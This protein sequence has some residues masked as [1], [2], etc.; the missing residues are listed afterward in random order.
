MN[1]S[2]SKEN[3]TEYNNYDRTNQH[4]WI[5]PVTIS[6]VLFCATLFLLISI[7]HYG[8]KTK[9][10]RQIQRYDSD[11]LNAGLVYSTLLLC[12][13]VCLLQYAAS[14]AF[15]N[16]GF[17]SGE[18]EL[19]DAVSHVE[20]CFYFLT[21]FSVELFLWLR[22]RAFYSNRMLNVHFSRTIR[23]VSFLSIFVISTFSLLA[24]VFETLSNHH[25]TNKG[26][27]FKP[28]N[29]FLTPYVIFSI[30]MVVFGQS[31][32]IG[33]LF[34]ALQQTNKPDVRETMLCKYFASCCSSNTNR[35]AANSASPTNPVDS[36]IP[37]RLTSPASSNRSRTKSS[38]VV[39]QILMQTLI[40][41]IISVITDIIVAITTYYI[42]DPEEHRELIIIMED[43]NAF[44]NLFIILLSF[45]QWKSIVISPY[46]RKENENTRV[47]V[48]SF[49]F[50]E[51]V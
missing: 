7:V 2:N 43:I 23:W 36:G 39:K 28:N 50:S 16:I 40:F 44:F 13:V 51:A 8:M 38:I 25:V 48:K 9:K 31:V 33:L 10:W 49:S 3:V 20:H 24:L 35:K 11:K 32:L 15:L 21:L 1:Y 45:L 18:D 29:R 37:S 26:C 30:C 27:K 6:I 41:A 34:H 4:H 47:S 19:C 5:L 46:R 17:R 14:L 42:T 22:Q 12:A